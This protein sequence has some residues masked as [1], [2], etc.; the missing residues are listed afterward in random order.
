[1]K[2][3]V[4]FSQK[5]GLRS[6]SE[7]EAQELVATG[8]WEYAP[9]SHCIYKDELGTTH[10]TIIGGGGGSDYNDISAPAKGGNGR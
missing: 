10:V 9:E 8:N 3:V 6:V 5:F 1:M 2:T 4:I 7:S